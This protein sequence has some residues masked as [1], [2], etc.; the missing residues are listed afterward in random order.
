[1]KNVGTR[2]WF[3]AQNAE[4]VREV[5]SS[6]IGDLCKTCEKVMQKRK[7]VHRQ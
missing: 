4:K 3:H 6:K 7:S 1:M 5:V 2:N